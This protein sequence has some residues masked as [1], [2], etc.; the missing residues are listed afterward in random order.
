MIRS[1]GFRLTAA[2]VLV[3]A[4]VLAG[5]AVVMHLVLD[6]ALV[7]QLD[8]RLAGSAAAIAGMAEDEP[9]EPEF[10]AESL[11]E[12]ERAARPG[13]FEVWVEGGRVLA[14]S[15]SLGARD[16][17]RLGGDGPEPA[18]ADLRL[19]DGRAGRAI[20]IRQPLRIEDA[21]PG[22]APSRRFVTVVAAMG[23]EDA[24]D[25]LAAASRWLW[26]LSAAAFSTAALATLVLVRRGLRPARAVAAQL[27]AL[28]AA[29]IGDPIP[30]TGL[31]TELAPIVSKLN[32]LLARLAASFARE[33]RFTADVSHELRTPLS[34]LRTTLEVAAAQDRPAAAYRAAIADATALA[35]Q[36]QALI[37]NLLL[38]ARLDARQIPVAAEPVDLRRLV[39]DCWR[40]FEAEAG[41]RRL[42]LSI[43]LPAD[44]AVVSDPEKLRI[45]VTNLLAN[46][47]AYT[48][49]GGS[50]TVRG[51]SAETLLEVA[52]SGPPIP[53]DLL[54]R[55]FDRF[56]RGDAARSGG[57]NCGIGL[58]LVRGVCAVLGLDASAANTPDG[59][60]RFRLTRPA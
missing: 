4:A 50:I 19:P 34:A 35:V 32:E 53:E 15:P 58:A 23:T 7:R 60:V 44:C 51:G 39:E 31:P 43:Q 59:G 48:V 18:H 26:I 8:L 28:D 16:L 46:A 9:A 45:V 57:V 38:L 14:R 6:R 42:R 1:L 54:P 33:R 49:P 17:P 36:M 52:D 27:D 37:G 12:F 10:E 2:V 24:R 25:T 13:Y 55:V 20:Q 41:E 30:T 3:L 11:P 56:S 22:A 5:F 29:V 40:P 47:T 21:R